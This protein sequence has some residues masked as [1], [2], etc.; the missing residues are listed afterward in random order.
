METPLAQQSSESV[1]AKEELIIAFVQEA[2]PTIDLSPGTAIRDIVIRIYAHLETRIQEQIDLALTA[3]SLLEISKNP[4]AVNE[5]QLER[6]LSNYGVTR[7]EGA[8][9]IGKVRLFL[10]SDSSVLIDVNTVLT[11]NNVEFNP[12]ESLVLLPFTSFSGLS[13]QRLISP[14]GSVYTALIDVVASNPGAA[15]NVRAGSLVAGLTP[16]ITGLISAKA[17]SDFTGGRDS[18]DNTVLLEKMKTGIVGKLFAGRDHIKAKLKTEFPGIVDVGCVG[19]LDPEMTRDLVNGVHTGGRVDLFVKSATY[20]SRIQEHLTPRLVSFNTIDREGLFEF[21]FDSAKAAG[22]YS[23]ESVKALLSQLG[24]FEIIS[25]SRRLSNS[26][27]H[28]IEDASKSAFSVFQTAIITFAVP[29]DS[30]IQ[31]WSLQEVTPPTYN[32]FVGNLANYINNQPTSEFFKFYVEYLKM[33]DLQEIQTYVDLASERT[34][35]AEMLV[36]APVPVM[37]SLQIRL[38]KKIGSPDLDIAA[39]KSSLASKFNSYGFGESIPGSA[40]VHVVYSNVP[41]G[42]TVDLPIHMYGVVI[43]PDLSKEVVFSSDALKATTNYDKGISPNNTAFFLE[44]NL[45]DISIKECS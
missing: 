28:Y 44:S 17:D 5:L 15:G 13:N 11:I 2:F 29:F 22:L 21:N 36:H 4:E 32:E 16:A 34:L 25:D 23:V 27:V 8:S 18:D 41:E 33:P 10:S 6:L 45:I 35:S 3:S 39:L 37:C 38:L 31:A 12:A 19:F 42:Y 1:F 24:S 14:S 26:G 7:S 40:L 20:P 30:M 43:N 9:S